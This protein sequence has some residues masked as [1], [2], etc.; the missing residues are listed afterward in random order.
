MRTLH[1]Q[2]V[3]NVHALTQQCEETRVQAA[4]SVAG[5]RVDA[6]SRLIAV[7]GGV[8]RMVC[9]GDAYRR[10]HGYMGGLSRQQVEREKA[11]M[12]L[13]YDSLLG[14]LRESEDKVSK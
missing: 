3:T 4:G 10:W 6:I 2:L 7:D 5:R 1:S 12:R 13:E 9:L 11:A 14:R 8:A